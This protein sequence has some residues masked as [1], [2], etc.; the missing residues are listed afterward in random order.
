MADVAWS[1]AD[2][3]FMRLALRLARRARGFTSPNPLVGAVLVRG[4]RLLGRGWHRR[5][6]EPHAEI[7]ALRDAARRGQTGRGATLYVTLEPCSTHGRTPPCTEALLAA[8]LRRVVVAE[9]DPNPR[10][11]GRGLELLRA[12]GLPVE[13]GLLGAEAARLNEAFHH[14]I[15][16]R[17]PW[18]TVKAAMT[19]D[20]KIA[21]PAGESRWITGEA[22]R[23]LAQEL[24]RDADAVLAGVNTVLADDPSLTVRGP[25]RG[26]APLRVLK[27]VRRLVLD[28]RARTP[29]TAR[30]VRDEWAALTTVLVTRAAPARKVEALARHVRVLVVPGRGGR[31]DL[32]WVMQRLGAEEVTHLLVEGGGEVQAA[33]FEAG[34]V[35]R[36]AFFYAPLVLGGRAARK[37]VA[38]SGFASR[39]RLPR[40]RAMEWRRVGGDLFLTARV[41]A[42]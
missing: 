27:P 35:Q 22:A 2:E 11:A 18:V 19:L 15:V 33:F 31:P 5:A 21:T 25:A 32:R 8:G 39:A 9:A 12:A 3:Q 20:G 17:T 38:G 30:L 1:P 28:S 13:V 36:V 34:L 26:D 37:A 14:W 24:R 4:D 10:H 40:L 6:G 29:L 23:A 41:E 16:R 7:E 42:A